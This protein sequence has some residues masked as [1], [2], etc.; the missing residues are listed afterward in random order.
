MTISMKITCINTASTRP[1]QNRIQNILKGYAFGKKEA[2]EALFPA[3]NPAG[4]DPDSKIKMS[5]LKNR[6]W[7][8]YVTGARHMNREKVVALAG[9]IMKDEE[10]LKTGSGMKG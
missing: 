7:K 10:V 9:T 3:M 6:E 8:W 5:S 4:E 2:R 1:G